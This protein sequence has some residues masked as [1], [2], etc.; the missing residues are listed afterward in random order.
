MAVCAIS[1]AHVPR[2]DVLILRLDLINDCCLRPRGVGVG[3]W[4][5]A[6]VHH[7]GC[8]DPNNQRGRQQRWSR[9]GGVPPVQNG[10][11]VSACG[12][13]W[14]DRVGCGCVGIGGVW[15]DVVYCG[16]V[17]WATV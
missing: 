8:A 7:G 5:E 11:T 4:E 12:A 16:M 6:A 10:R 3:A 1:I 14:W 2:Y 17:V 13:L 9:L 15:F